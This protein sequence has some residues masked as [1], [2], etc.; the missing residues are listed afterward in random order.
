[1]EVKDKIKRIIKN[2]SKCTFMYIILEVGQ[3]DEDSEVYG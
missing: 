2:H 3:M 1:M